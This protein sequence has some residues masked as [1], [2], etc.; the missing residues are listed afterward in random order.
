MLIAVVA[1]SGESGRLRPLSDDGRPAGPVQKVADLV[2]AVREREAD[3]QPR[4][5][6]PATGE[7][8]PRLLRAGARVERCHDLELTEALLLGHE[9][10]WGDPRGLAA[11]H[12]RLTG[13]PVPSDPPPRAAA[14]P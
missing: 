11:A 14:P 10:S 1:G 8:Y 13:A 7:I 12:A 3:G 2:R 9:G 6:W 5:L 4:W